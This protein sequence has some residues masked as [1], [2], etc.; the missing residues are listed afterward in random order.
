[1]AIAWKPAFASAAIVGRQISLH[2]PVPW[3]STIGVPFDGPASCTYIFR[4]P[5][6]TKCP[7]DGAACSALS[8]SRVAAVTRK[9]M[10]MATISNKMTAS[11]LE[12]QRNAVRSKTLMICGLT[13]GGI[14]P[15][16]GGVPPYNGGV[17][18]NVQGFKGSRVHLVQN[19]QRSK[20]VHRERERLNT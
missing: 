4:S 6:G 3:T 17:G 16:N 11:P 1:M 12:I 20:F 9:M 19:V 5:A 2:A 10:A 18:S 13:R 8:R 7:V 14:L 15:Y